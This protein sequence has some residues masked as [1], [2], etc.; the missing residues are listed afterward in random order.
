[1][2]EGSQLIIK[3]SAFWL[4][5]NAICFRIE[6]GSGTMKFGRASGIAMLQD[7]R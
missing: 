2:R 3:I 7:Y 4:P 1:V 5:M 6:K